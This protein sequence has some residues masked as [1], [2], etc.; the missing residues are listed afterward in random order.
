MPSKSSSR[1]HVPDLISTIKK[2]ESQR[3]ASL[4]HRRSQSETINTKTV[5]IDSQTR[6]SNVRPRYLEPKPIHNKIASNL[7]VKA[8]KAINHSSSDSSRNA[9]PAPN[10]HPPSTKKQQNK[11]NDSTNMSRDSLAS[12]AKTNKLAKNKSSHDIDRS[13]DSLGES[14]LSSIKT[15]K[16]LSQESIV[17]LKRK[18]NLNKPALKSISRS[19]P[20]INKQPSTTATPTMVRP[21]SNRFAT[22]TRPLSGQTTNENSPSSVT[23]K[24][25]RLSSLSSPR[26]VHKGLSQQVP[27]KKSFLSA[28]SK[29]ILAKKQSLNHADSTRSV[30]A[31]VRNERISVNKS[32]STS[33]VLHS[34]STAKPNPFNT[35][36]HLRRTAKLEDEKVL[37]KSGSTKSIPVTNRNG[38]GKIMNGHNGKTENKIEKI[39]VEIESD[40]EESKPL[41]IDSKLERSSTFCKESSDAPLGE[42]HIIE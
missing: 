35:T 16:T 27:V 10:R 31:A 4:G 36:L 17:Q 12:P 42:L 23:T 18:D 13:V 40:L 32:N 33:N 19:N 34:N 39:R 22:K 7:T 37:K 2:S 21:L 14:L 6:L 5:Q 25:S 24:S 8:G 26:D 29:E 1:A 9:S 38:N 11:E 3:P 20:M 28:K 15:E 41:R 30:P